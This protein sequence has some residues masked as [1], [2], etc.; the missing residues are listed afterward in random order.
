MFIQ[1]GDEVVTSETLRYEADGVVM[2]GF[3]AKPAAPARACVLVAHMWG[4]QNDFVREKARLLAEQGY[5]ALAIDVYGEARL[6]SG[7]DEAARWMAPFIAD[8]AMLRRRLIAAAEAARGLAGVEAVGVIGYCFGGLCALELARSGDPIAAAVS[9]HGML[10]TDTP[11]QHGQVK[12]SVLALHGHE[13]PLAPPQDVRAL[14]AELTAAGV[15]WQLHCYGHA[16]HAFTNPAL[17]NHA[18]GMYYVPSAD[19]RSWRATLN[20]LEER[21]G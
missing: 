5:V 10:H 18:G 2:H 4:G 16:A 11:A 7:P 21:L 9:L 15:D 13:D 6:A 20:F 12:A 14:E 17:H 1:R 3:L 8:R 19:A